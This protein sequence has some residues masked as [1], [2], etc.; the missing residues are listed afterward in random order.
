MKTDIIKILKFLPF[1][2]S[3][4][5]QP[6]NEAERLCIPPRHN[7]VTMADPDSELSNCDH[8]LLRVC[9]YLNKM[10]ALMVAKKLKKY[11]VHTK[12]IVIH[13]E[14]KVKFCFKKRGS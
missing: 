11:G 1:A 10:S 14:K 4:R 8:L 6:V 3:F 2:R 9:R 5:K 7:L 12:L 13:K